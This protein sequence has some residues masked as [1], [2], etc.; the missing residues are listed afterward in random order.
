MVKALL[1]GAGGQVELSTKMGCEA[2]NRKEGYPGGLRL[3]VRGSRP[4]ETMTGTSEPGLRALQQ[5]KK[6]NRWDSVWDQT[7][8]WA[9][10]QRQERG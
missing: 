8:S 9:V 2:W 4:C 7:G 3:F 1:A 10:R 6:R 5:A